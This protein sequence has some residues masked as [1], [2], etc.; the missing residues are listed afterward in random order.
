MVSHIALNI[1][2]TAHFF[3]ILLEEEARAWSALTIH[4]LTKDNQNLQMEREKDID[5]VTDMVLHDLSSFSGS[6]RATREKLRDIVSKVA[7]LGLE[8]AKLP[9]EIRPMTELNPG[10]PFVADMMKDMDPEEEDVS[11]MTTI[12][13]SYPWVKVTYDETGK[14]IYQ[15]TYLCKARVSCIC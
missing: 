12:I 7:D 13:L 3:M 5:A 9:F 8:L 6:P 2:N 1:Y 15:S 14:S 10:D 4:R 11:G